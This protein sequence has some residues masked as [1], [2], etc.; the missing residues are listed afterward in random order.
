MRRSSSRRSAPGRLRGALV[1]RRWQDKSSSIARDELGGVRRS[2]RLCHDLRRLHDAQ[3]TPRL[4]RAERYALVRVTILR[5]DMV[6]ALHEP[7]FD[8]RV[9]VHERLDIQ[10]LDALG[11]QL[12]K[13]A[14]VAEHRLTSEPN[15]RAQPEIARLA[16]IVEEIGE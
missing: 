10:A 8:H 3:R 9:D 5:A 11:Y 16:H 15:E 14:P 6:A 7:L 12:A 13:A 2:R 4:R 1:S